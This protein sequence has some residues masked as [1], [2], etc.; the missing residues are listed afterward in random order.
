MLWIGTSGWQYQHWREAFYPKGV[1]QRR[2]LPY[3]TEHFATAELNAS[4]YRLPGRA[5]FEG[6]RERTPADFLMAVKMSRYLTHIRRLREPEEPVERL[7]ASASGLGDRLGP[8][9]VQLPPT[10]KAAPD[11]LARTLKAFPASVRVA[12]EP[13]HESWWTDEVRNLLESHG[14][15]LCLADRDSRWLTPQWRTADWGYVRFHWGSGEP[16]PC[17]PTPVLAQ[18]LTDMTALWGPSEDVFVYFNNDPMACAIADAR[19]LAA[20]CADRGIPTTRVD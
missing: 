14:A 11:L 6:W 17:Y 2:W 8:V 20:M 13:R 7:L 9:L 5:T 16:S 12:V 4:F 1:G 19:A 18:R 15:A 10:L 3:F